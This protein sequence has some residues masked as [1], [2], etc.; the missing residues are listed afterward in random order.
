MSS[1][2]FRKPKQNINSQNMPSRPHLPNPTAPHTFGTLLPCLPNT[3]AKN[4]NSYVYQRISPF[5]T[6]LRQQH[7]YYPTCTPPPN[8]WAYSGNSTSTTLHA[9]SP[10]YFTTGPTTNHLPFQLVLQV[11]PGSR[12]FQP[13]PT[14]LQFNFH[15]HSIM[16]F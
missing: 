12:P 14:Q 10:P 9:S 3:L 15:T 7:L 16:E 4:F 5:P 2:L 11:W 8:Y 13:R 1:Y 6:I